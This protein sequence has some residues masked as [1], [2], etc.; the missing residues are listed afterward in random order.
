M[1]QRR[2]DDTGRDTLLRRARSAIASTIGANIELAPSTASP[3]TLRAGAFVTLRVRGDLRGCIGYPQG[4]RLLVDVVEK[5][6]ISAAVSDPRFPAV[7]A[8]E[9]PLIDLEISVLGPI[10]RVG[11]ISEIEIGRHGLIA[12]FGQRR[13]LLLPQVA[14]EWEWDK[15][16]FASQTCVKAGLPKDA[17]R[18]NAT[19][20]KFEAEVFGDVP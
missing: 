12:E 10:E 6:A 19:L 1:N 4:D 20:F 18:T 16:E 17:W 3:P 9:W 15:E 5:C 8:S 11:D 14:V 2:L 7:S 13:G